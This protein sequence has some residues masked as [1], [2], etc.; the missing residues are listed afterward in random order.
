MKIN[1]LMFNKQNPLFKNSPHIVVKHLWNMCNKNFI[2]VTNTTYVEV[3]Q[4]VFKKYKVIDENFS[5]DNGGKLLEFDIFSSMYDCLAFKETKGFFDECDCPPPKFWVAF[6]DDKII[7]Y[8]PKEYL[9]LAKLGVDI[10]M[11]ESL[12]W[13]TPLK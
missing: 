6:I 12:R 9:S 4:S 11:S 7:A 3:I 2:E 1:S 8:I 10:S 5:F 13:I